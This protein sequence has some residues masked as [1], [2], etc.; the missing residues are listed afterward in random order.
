M[1]FASWRQSRRFIEAARLLLYIRIANASL[2]KPLIYDI[3]ISTNNP[4]KTEDERYVYDII[5]KTHL[6]N[7][8]MIEMLD[9]KKRNKLT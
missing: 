1:R 6:I 3:I 2:T 8:K 4:P 7:E 9:Y 5:Q